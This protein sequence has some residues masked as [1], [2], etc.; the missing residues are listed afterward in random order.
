[1]GRAL[2]DTFSGQFRKLLVAEILLDWLVVES[3]NNVAI[4]LI[5]SKLH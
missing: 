2:F 5:F 3:R 4:F 1:M